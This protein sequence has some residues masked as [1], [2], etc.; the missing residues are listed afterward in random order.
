MKV[1]SIITDNNWDQAKIKK[2][3]RKKLRIQFMILNE[4]L[5][6]LRSA[7]LKVVQQNLQ[8]TGNDNILLRYTVR[9]EAK[10]HGIG[11]SAKQVFFFK[12]K[13]IKLNQ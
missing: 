4:L 6:K 8:C 9:M 10:V 2:N 5:T 3:L 12:L 7:K 13:P 11:A 1:T